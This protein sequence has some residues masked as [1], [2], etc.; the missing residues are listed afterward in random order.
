MHVN[1][2]IKIDEKILEPEVS[3][4]PTAITERKDIPGEIPSTTGLLGQS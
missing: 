3:G 1:N 2:W 4:S